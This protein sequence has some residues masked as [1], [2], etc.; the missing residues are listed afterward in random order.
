[1][2]VTRVIARNVIWN[3]VA[4]G[5]NLLAGFIVAPFLVHRLGQTGYGLWILVASL[6]DYFGLLDMGVRGAVG[7]Q[8]ALHHAKQ[9]RQGVNET[10]STALAILSGGGVL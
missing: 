7:R 8:I 2:S 3:W 5:A 10:L 9:N 4:L 1:M 6:I